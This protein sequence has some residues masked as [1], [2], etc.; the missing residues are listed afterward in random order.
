MGV[1]ARFA[2]KPREWRRQNSIFGSYC[3]FHFR[4]LIAVIEQNA[5]DSDEAHQRATERMNLFCALLSL[6]YDCCYRVDEYRTNTD[7]LDQLNTVALDLLKAG[8]IPEGYAPASEQPSPEYISLQALEV[9]LNSLS[10]SD[11]DR[12]ERAVRMFHA[13]PLIFDRSPS[14]AVVALV[15]AGEALAEQSPDRCPH[16]SNLMHQSRKRYRHWLCDG[17]SGQAQTTADRYAKDLYDKW[18]SATAHKAQFRH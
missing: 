2:S 1:E 10:H 12:L 4:P 14:W 11:H 9:I 18:R 16:C 3:L 7:T 6:C 17:L 5:L 8:E 13:A 15:S